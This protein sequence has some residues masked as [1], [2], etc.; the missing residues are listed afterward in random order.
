M[1]IT[2]DKYFKESAGITDNDLKA[3]SLTS[4][5]TEAYKIYENSISQISQSIRQHAEMVSESIAETN[6]FRTA[7]LTFN[8]VIPS[9]AMFVHSPFP[10]RYNSMAQIHIDGIS[11]M[12]SGADASRLDLTMGYASGNPAYGVTSQSLI[13][14]SSGP[15]YVGLYGPNSWSL[16]LQDADLQNEWITSGNWIL[17]TPTNI[18][19]SISYLSVTIDYTA[20]LRTS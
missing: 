19:G 3:P 14:Q 20:Y 8:I 6:L 4:N 18:V 5:N 15:G 16:Y 12:S 10:L 7:S 1:G 9:G 17:A 2:L 13:S 11:L